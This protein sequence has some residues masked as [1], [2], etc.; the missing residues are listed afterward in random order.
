MATPHVSGV[1]ALIL[2]RNPSLTPDGVR[3]VLQMTADDL[4]TPGRDNYYGYGLVNAEAALRSMAQ[5][6]HLSLNVDPGQA[7]YATRQTLTLVVTSF[8]E[9]NPALNSTLAVTATGPNNYYYYESQPVSIAANAVVDYSFR[10]V[11]PD[12][13]GKYFVEVG[14]VPA[15]LTAYDAIYLNVV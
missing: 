5:P 4:G 12:V 10:W 8:N 15:Q 3:G 11:I 1:A 7:A 9:L 6:I 14:L 2:A 13:A